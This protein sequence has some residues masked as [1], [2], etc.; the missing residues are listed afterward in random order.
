MTEE[1]LAIQVREVDCVKIDNVNLPKPSQDEVLEQLATNAASS[2]QENTGLQAL[3]SFVSKASARGR[4][5]RGVSNGLIA[6]LDP[7]GTCS[8]Y[9][10]EHKWCSSARYRRTCLTDEFSDGPSD[11]W[12]NLS[13]VIAGGRRWG[14][15][16]CAFCAV[17]CC[18]CGC[19]CGTCICCC[20][21]CAA[22]AEAAAVGGASLEE[23]VASIV[24]LPLASLGYQVRGDQP[25]RQNGLHAIVARRRAKRLGKMLELEF[26]VQ[27]LFG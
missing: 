4:E 6:T 18:C 15:A 22:P 10:E 9:Q 12:L 11:C 7:R 19:C 17:G 5:S 26:R 2:N 25:S 1:K 3:I 8:C 14:V 20:S 16:G 23:F 21:S 13:R 24:G 27:R